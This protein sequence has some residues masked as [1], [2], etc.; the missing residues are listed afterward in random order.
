LA[1]TPKNIGSIGAKYDAIGK[2]YTHSRAPDPRIAT[3]LR[4]TLGDIE[5]LI[6]V[7]AGTGSYEH[8]DLD[9]QAVEPSSIM[10]AQRPPGAAPVTKAVAEDLPFDDNSFDGAQAVLTLHHWSDWRKGIDELLRV[11]RRRIVILSYDPDRAN[12]F[13]FLRDYLPEGAALDRAQFPPVKELVDALGGATVRPL[14]IPWDC[15][16]GFLCACWRRPQAYLDPQVRAGISTFSTVDAVAIK[17]ALSNLE[18]DLKLGEWQQRNANIL[19]KREADFG[20]RLIVKD[21]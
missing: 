1:D 10:I 3:A 9:I 8:N 11:A 13:W 6:N 18:A 21:L 14:P 2:S 19:D 7:G 15:I 12:D 17:R 5:T 4:R 16:D 20:Y